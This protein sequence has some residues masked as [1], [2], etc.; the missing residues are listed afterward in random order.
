[1]GNVFAVTTEGAITA[2]AAKTLLQIRGSATMRHRILGWSVTGN[3]TSA[4]ATP[5]PVRFLRQTTDGTAGSTCTEVTAD[6]NATAA[7]FTGHKNFSAEPTAGEV[8]DSKH[9]HPQLGVDAWYGDKGPVIAAT[10]TS[11]FGLEVTPA[12]SVDCIATIWVEEL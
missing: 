7:T 6:P 11:R 5:V 12:A 4:T 1:M 10:T 8:W 9:F 3:S 2:A